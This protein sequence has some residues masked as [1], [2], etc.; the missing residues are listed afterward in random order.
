[1]IKSKLLCILIFIVLIDA[2]YDRI[3][4]KYCN[5]YEYMSNNRAIQ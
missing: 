1:M 4:H 5:T 3:C 2:E